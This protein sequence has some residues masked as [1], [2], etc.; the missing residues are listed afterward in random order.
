MKSL[1]SSTSLSFFKSD[2]PSQ[3]WL[4][5]RIGMNRAGSPT[6]C[7]GR[8]A[9]ISATGLC[10][11]DVTTLIVVKCTTLKSF[12]LSGEN[13]PHLF[14]VFYVKC[15]DFHQKRAY[16]SRSGGSHHEPRGV[17]DRH[18]AEVRTAL[19]VHANSAGRRRAGLHSHSG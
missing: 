8:R 3:I 16:S 1:F 13:K 6:G 2:K 7:F 19:S 17:E 4:G 12:F 15:T 10:R 11:G 14:S 5:P 18:D 9:M